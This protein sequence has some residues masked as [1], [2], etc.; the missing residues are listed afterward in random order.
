MFVGEIGFP[1][2]E[3]LHGIRWWEVKSII[4]GYNCRYR[5]SWSQTRWQTYHLMSVSMADLKKAGINSP[6]DLIAFPWETDHR[7][8]TPDEVAQIC[9]ELAAINAERGNNK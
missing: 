8:P 1:R 3:F 4:R 2:R 9:N 6:K 7:M 5:N